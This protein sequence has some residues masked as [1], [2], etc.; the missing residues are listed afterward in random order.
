MIL[1]CSGHAPAAMMFRADLRP[2]NVVPKNDGVSPAGLSSAWGIGFFELNLTPGNPTMSYE[3]TFFNLS[4][5][6]ITG[7]HFHFGHDPSLAQE[8][9]LPGRQLISSEID[10]VLVPISTPPL[11]H[12]GAT[13]P[14]GPHLLNVYKAPREDDDQLQID[15]ANNRISGVWDNSDVNFG[16]DGVRDPGDS[17]AIGSALA[18]IL[19]EEVYV[20]VH[21]VNFPAPNTG[22]IRG[23]IVAVPEPGPAL[24]VL[25]GGL[26]VLPV[27]MRSRRGLRRE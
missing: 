2:E 21:S 23:Q 27:R 8:I 25:M 12:T 18:D 4:L 22:E 13:G 19:I 11:N 15:V 6:D 17:V 10:E 5:N 3:L 16:G 9:L 24:L 26:L 1:G 20:Q 14:N 7:V